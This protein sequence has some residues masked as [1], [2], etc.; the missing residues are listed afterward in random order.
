MENIKNKNIQLLTHNTAETE[1]FKPSEANSPNFNEFN[2]PQGKDL[3]VLS[4]Y[5]NKKR[6]NVDFMKKIGLSSIN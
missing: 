1:L 4:E 2:F 5:Y 3:N 6:G